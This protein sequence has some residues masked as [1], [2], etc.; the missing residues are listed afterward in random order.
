MLVALSLLVPLAPGAFAQE[1]KPA[2]PPA[3]AALPDACAADAQKICPKGEGAARVE[4]LRSH[5]S[6][7]SAACKS[8]LTA[9][10][11]EQ[12]AVGAAGGREGRGRGGFAAACR[13]DG[14]KLCADAQG[15]ARFQCLAEKES[16]LSDGCKAVIQR[17]RSMDRRG[18]GGQR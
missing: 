12:P 3:T 18:G 14:E 6:E 8:A 9:P 11:A 13:A 2:A 10:P 17:F 7:V 4:C 5:E 16:E 15:R 1:N